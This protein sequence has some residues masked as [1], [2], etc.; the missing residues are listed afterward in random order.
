MRLPGGVQQGGSGP[1][2]GGQRAHPSL[3]QP[4]TSTLKRPKRLEKARISDPSLFYIWGLFAIPYKQ[5]NSDRISTSHPHFALQNARN[6]ALFWES[7]LPTSP[8]RAKTGLQRAPKPLF[9]PSSFQNRQKPP[10]NVPPGP[11]TIRPWGDRGPRPNV[12]RRPS[13]RFSPS[14]RPRLY[15]KPSVQP[16]S[17]AAQH[18]FLCGLA[19]TT[20]PHPF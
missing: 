3:S 12:N 15:R 18:F 20:Q 19:P 7:H 5:S 17:P 14:R 8:N 2:Q 16:R 4:V 11:P 13:P 10:S 6:L 1:R 9:C